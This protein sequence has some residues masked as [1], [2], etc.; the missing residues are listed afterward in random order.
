MRAAHGIDITGINSDQLEADLRLC[1][2][3][4]VEMDAFCHDI[5]GERKFFC[6]SHCRSII[7]NPGNYILDHTEPLP[8]LL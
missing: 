6:M 8:D 1:C 5:G 2:K 7:T 3:T 4:Q